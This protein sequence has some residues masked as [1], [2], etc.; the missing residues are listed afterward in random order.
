MA[1]INFIHNYIL[2]TD[3]LKRAT[4]EF[5]ELKKDEIHESVITPFSKSKKEIIEFKFTLKTRPNIAF[6]EVVQKN[7]SLEDIVNYIAS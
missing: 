7:Q 2:F 1:E 4:N 5:V 6:E 3:T